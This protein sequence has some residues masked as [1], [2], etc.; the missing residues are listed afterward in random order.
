MN[1]GGIWVRLGAGGVGIT[2]WAISGVAHDIDGL[3]TT[4]SSEVAEA[5][6]AKHPNGAT[7]LDHVVVLTP[8]FERT[9]RVLEAAGMPLSRIRDGG[10]FRQGFRRLGPA[11]LELGEANKVPQ[12]PAR[13]WG[14]VVIVEDLDALR[15]RLGEHL[16][17][18]K[19]AVQAGRQIATLRSSAGL[20]EAVAFMTPAS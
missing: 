17:L 10:G 15:A 8:D 9:G 12:G 4:P 3:P 7:G 6:G 16:G 5:S 20:S 14:L 2:S 18:I 13:F 1:L 11:I 19:P